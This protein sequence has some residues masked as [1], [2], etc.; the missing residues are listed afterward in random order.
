M[1]MLVLHD[2][3]ASP[4]ID[5]QPDW[6]HPIEIPRE[7]QVDELGRWLEGGTLFT[8]GGWQYV[9]DVETFDRAVVP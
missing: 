3:Y 6:D 1:S 7:A 8:Y 5:D 9:C 4:V 2:F